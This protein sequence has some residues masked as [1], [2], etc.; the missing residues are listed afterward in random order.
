VLIGIY[1][2]L[3]IAQ[4]TITG[5]LGPTVGVVLGALVGI[6]VNSLALTLVT[7]SYHRFKEAATSV[8]P[9]D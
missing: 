5:I 7:L 6:L 8:V 9:A 2:G 1:L 4:V 3:G